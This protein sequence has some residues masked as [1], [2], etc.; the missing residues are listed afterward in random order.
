MRFEDRADD[1]VTVLRCGIHR[2]LLEAERDI[3]S[4]RIAQ[5]VGIAMSEVLHG[6]KQDDVIAR[7]NDIGLDTIEPGNGIV[8]QR[9]AQGTCRPGDI[10]ELVDPLRGEYDGDVLLVLCQYIHG[11]AR[12]LG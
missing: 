5:R 4:P 11:K 10:R 6:A 8:D 7:L 1:G 12:R 2:R 3:T 9:I